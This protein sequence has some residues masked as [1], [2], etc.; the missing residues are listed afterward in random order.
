[1]PADLI[2]STEW[3]AAHLDDPEVRVVDIRGYVITRQLE[4]GVEQAI[5]QHAHNEYL[6]GHIP[7]AVYVDWTWD[8]IDPDNPVAVQIAGPA[9][10]AEAMGARGVGDNTHVVAVDHKGGQFAT[11]L[12]WALRYYGHGNVS[13]LEGGMKRWVDEG[14]PVTT[15]APTVPRLVFTP[16]EQPEQRVTAEALASRL[17]EAELQVI[18]ARDHAQFT[19]AKRRGAHGGHIPGAINLPRELFFDQNNNFVAIDALRGLVEK[20]EID[21]SRPVIAYCNGG[22]AATVVLFNLHRLGFRHLVNYDGS[23]NEWGNRA[24]LPVARGPN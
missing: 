2:V 22:V 13:V 6:E 24:D 21:S 17:P 10:F 11:R 14:R 12:W 7:G 15:A 9:R 1:M 8:I 20:S 3:L 4:P 5:Y 19:G 18:D 23:W 16:R